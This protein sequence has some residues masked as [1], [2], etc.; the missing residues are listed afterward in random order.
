MRLRRPVTRG[1]DPRARAGCLSGA[2]YPAFAAG[3]G[4]GPGALA[5]PPRP[6]RRRPEGILRLMKFST[7]HGSTDCLNKRCLQLRDCPPRRSRPSQ[8]VTLV[9][10]AGPRAQVKRLP[11]N[12]WVWAGCSLRRR[13]GGFEMLP[14]AAPGS[15][16]NCEPT[17]RSIGCFSGFRFRALSG[18]VSGLCRVQAGSLRA[19]RRPSDFVGAVGWLFLENGCADGGW[20]VRPH[21][22]R[23]RLPTTTPL[24]ST[25]PYLSSSPAFQLLL[26]QPDCEHR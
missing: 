20:A 24:S 19:E 11:S 4:C 22:A 3:L 6:P 8:A 12:R 21:G 15:A 18:Q 14:Q 5:D 7:S 1:D 2:R 16:A 25:F 9:V 17:R 23:T 26:P 13:F 10:F